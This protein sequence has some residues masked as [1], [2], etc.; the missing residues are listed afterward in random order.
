MDIVLIGYIALEATEKT[1]NL[2]ADELSERYSM[3]YLSKAKR[4]CEELSCDKTKVSEIALKNCENGYE[5]I[6]LSD[7]GIF[8][9]L[10]NLSESLVKRTFDEEDVLYKECIKG[11]TSFV[12]PVLVKQ[13]TIEILE[14]F[15]AN[16]YTYPSKGT[17][18][19]AC[20]N[21]NAMVNAFSEEGIKAAVIGSINSSNE[22]III[23]GETKRF[24][25]PDDRLLKDEQ[26]LI[27]NK[28]S[29]RKELL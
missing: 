5:L 13:E 11:V 4:M 28:I 19:M 1:L 3:N 6:E 23:N 10:W 14:Y 25:T 8:G 21:A 9:G 29:L 17:F 18:L 16:P 15:D 22:R 2:K 26:G 20:N 12:E 27:N 24:L 7:T